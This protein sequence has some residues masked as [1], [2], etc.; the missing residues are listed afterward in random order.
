M[1]ISAPLL[2]LVAVVSATCV[3]GTDIMKCPEDSP[4]TSCS[5]K[6]G[7]ENPSEGW[8]CV[9]VPGGN[10]APG[11]DEEIQLVEH[12][13][14]GLKDINSLAYRVVFHNN[15]LTYPCQYPGW[16]SNENKLFGFSRGFVEVMWQSCM[17][18]WRA[19]RGPKEPSNKIMLW[20][21]G[22]KNSTYKPWQH[23]EQNPFMGFIDVDTPYLI[24]LQGLKDRCTYEL[25]D[26]AGKI[27]KTATTPQEAQAPGP[28][29]FFSLYFGG[30]ETTTQPVTV[31]YSRDTRCR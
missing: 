26:G 12:G 5:P 17:F 7:K 6:C 20:G 29:Y 2:L 14:K 27:I 10:H 19:T 28:S 31:S 24:S 1:R 22:W 8:A 23:P 3:V 4:C 25:A 18:S 11:F 13:F 15:T 21:Y 30:T 9:T 16:C